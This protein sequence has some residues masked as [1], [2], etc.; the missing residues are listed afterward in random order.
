MT[1]PGRFPS[2]ICAVGYHVSYERRRRR[3]AAEA[4]W[5]TDNW[6]S[7]SRVRPPLLSFSVP[8][9]SWK[10]RSQDQGSASSHCSHRQGF[11]IKTKAENLLSSGLFRKVRR[12]IQTRGSGALVVDGGCF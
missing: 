11:N 3:R 4:E 5:L 1:F 7:E 2:R 10:C 6:Q 8:T 9:L 12:P